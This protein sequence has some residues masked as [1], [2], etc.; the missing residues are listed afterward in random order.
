MPAKNGFAG[1]KS[2]NG[3]LG[4]MFVTMSAC[5]CMKKDVLRVL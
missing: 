1:L 5:A 2:R 3:W 4:S